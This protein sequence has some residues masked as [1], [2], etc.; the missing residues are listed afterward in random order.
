MLELTQ[1]KIAQK[2]YEAELEKF[3]EKER[4]KKEKIFARF[5][6]T[7]LEKENKKHHKSG[8]Q[9]ST[10]RRASKEQSTSRIEHQHE[11][12]LKKIY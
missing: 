12:E 6:K 10:R 4:R 3:E 11:Q 2:K 7:A 1:Q 8:S 5:M 9:K